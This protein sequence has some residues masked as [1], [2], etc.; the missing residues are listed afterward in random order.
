MTAYLISMATYVGFFMILALALNLQWGMT[1]MVNFGIA[2]FYA[3]GAYTSG[4]LTTKAGWPVGL[5][6]PMAALTGMAAG[7]LVAL[8]S[9]RLREDFLAVVTLGFGEIVRRIALKGGV[10]T[11]AVALAAPG[12]VRAAE[13]INV[14]SL[15]PN[16]GGGGPFGPKITASHKRVA[17]LVN[18]QG[19][20]LGRQIDL[21]P[22]RTPRP[23]RSRRCAPPT[24]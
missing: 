7:A 1:G 2:G 20:V 6:M 18:G 21:T 24:S 4:L 9:I 15:T 13:T 17:D 14:G 19:G 5:A 22:R 11:L 12:I 3:L 16:T 23:T 10:A 8:L